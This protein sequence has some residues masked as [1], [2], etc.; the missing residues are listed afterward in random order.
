ME[1]YDS[2]TIQCFTQLTDI[3]QGIPDVAAEADLFKIFL[4]TTPILIGGTSASSPAFAGF[5]SLLNDAR[6][7]AG[8][9]SLGFLNPLIY[10]IGELEPTAFNDITVGNNPGCGTNGFNVSLVE[11]ALYCVT[12][13]RLQPGHE[14]L[15]PCHRVRH[16]E[17]REAERYRHRSSTPRLPLDG[18]IE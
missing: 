2:L 17:L 9:P 3:V 12:F 6:L 15:G 7:K 8:L 11:S 16:S 5:V 10:A 13:S 4:S 18:R 14:G 1:G